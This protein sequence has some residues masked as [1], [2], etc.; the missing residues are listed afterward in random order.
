MENASLIV[1][2]FF[3]MWFCML[4]Y[5]IQRNSQEIR[6]LKRHT[7]YSGIPKMKNPLPPPESK[8]KRIKIKPSPRPKPNR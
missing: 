5:M 3:L 8:K 7:K 6:K 2:L 4:I 1:D